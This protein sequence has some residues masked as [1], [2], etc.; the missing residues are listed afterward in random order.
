MSE[1]EN[2]PAAGQGIVLEEHKTR[3]GGS[4]CKSSP[5]RSQNV[6]VAFLGVRALEE[7]DCQLDAQNPQYGVIDS[8]FWNLSFL[9]QIC[10]ICGVDIAFHIHVQPG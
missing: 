9:Y 5:L 6:G 8:I 4:A 3:F 2:G 1:R 10:E 7:S